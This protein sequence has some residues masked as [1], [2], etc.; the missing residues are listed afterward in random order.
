M[1]ALNLVIWASEPPPPP[2]GPD[3]VKPKQKKFSKLNKIPFSIVDQIP[4]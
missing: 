1:A 3:R 2:H 4:F